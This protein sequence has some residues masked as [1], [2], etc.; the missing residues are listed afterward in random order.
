MPIS[1]SN[2]I[3]FVHMSAKEAQVLAQIVC[4][5]WTDQSDA[6]LLVHRGQR[7]D[8]VSDRVYF[9]CQNGEK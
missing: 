7:I 9:G 6:A 3:R 5:G 1:E 4:T 8:F 2:K